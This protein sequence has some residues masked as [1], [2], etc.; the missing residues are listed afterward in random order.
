MQMNKIIKAAPFLFAGTILLTGCGAESVNTTMKV[1]DTEKVSVTM[2]IGYSKD[3]E[4]DDINQDLD[5]VFNISEDDKVEVEN[6]STDEYQ[7]KS[8]EWEKVTLDEFESFFD[9]DE[10][11]KGTIQEISGHYVV[12]LP[13]TDSFE[14]FNNSQ[15]AVEMPGKIIN[16]P[17]ATVDGNKATWNLADFDKSEMILESEKSNP[18]PAIIAGTLGLMVIGAGF[19]YYRSHRVNPAKNSTEE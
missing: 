19:F 7:G 15:F 11:D 14:D 16:A 8:Y 12:S 18:A 2:D 13:Y 6:Y 5:T 17:G 9:A 4:K 1:H 3:V 10:S